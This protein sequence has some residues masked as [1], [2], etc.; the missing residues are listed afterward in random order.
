MTPACYLVQFGKPGFVGHFRNACAEVLER[1]DRVVVCGP[2]GLEP[3]FVLCPSTTR[4]QYPTQDGEVLRTV[5]PDDDAAAGRFTETGHVLLSAAGDAAEATGLPLTFVDVEFTLDGTA[6]LHALPWDACDADPLLARLS[7]RFGLPVRL[8]DLSRTPTAKDEPQPVGCGK[9]GCGS[10]SGGCSSCGTGGGC[11][12]GSCSKGKVKS[13][14]ELTAY[15]ADLRQK[16][17]AQGV[18]RT[19]LA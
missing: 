3:G 11:S 13:A 18:A 14:G 17:E 5:T 9:P 12:T 4:F 10:E 8:L 2:R 15:F 19:P 1:G 6:I 16:M 7:E